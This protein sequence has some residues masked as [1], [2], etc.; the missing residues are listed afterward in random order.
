MTALRWLALSAACVCALMGCDPIQTGIIELQVVTLDASG[1]ELPVEGAECTLDEEVTLE[2]DASGQVQFSG[3]SEGWHTL[4]CLADA[5]VPQ[6]VGVVEVEVP[7]EAGHPGFVSTTLALLPME[8]PRS[9]E[10]SLLPRGAHVRWMPPAMTGGVP[11]LGYRL[12]AL[13][14]GPVRDVEGDATEALLTPLEPGQAYS[15]GV[16]ARTR[17]GVGPETVSKAFVFATVPTQP[18]DVIAVGEATGARITWA[19]PATDGGA[20]ILAYHVIATPGGLRQTAEPGTT[21]LSFRKLE[22]GVTYTFSVVA[23]NVVGEGPGSEPS[24]EVTIPE[25]PPRDGADE[26]LPLDEG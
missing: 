6:L 1:R 18:L 11:V 23:E 14:D 5:H 20:P 24:S 25:E 19:A 8:A 9:V 12:R 2:T 4:R 15:V 7:R 21:V 22:A 26:E 17:F 16:A 10:V 3:A 13:P